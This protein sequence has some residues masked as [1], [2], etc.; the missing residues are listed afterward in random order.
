[1]LHRSARAAIQPARCRGQ[2]AARCRSRFGTSRQCMSTE[3][4]A[5]P[6][7]R[8]CARAVVVLAEDQVAARCRTRADRSAVTRVETRGVARARPERG[9]YPVV[10]G[11]ETDRYVRR[12]REAGSNTRPR[13]GF[14]VLPKDARSMRF[15]NQL[16]QWRK[17]SAPHSTKGRSNDAKTCRSL[18]N[19]VDHSACLPYRRRHSTPAH[20]PT[21]SRRSCHD[22]ETRAPRDART[23]A[24]ERD[25]D[26]IR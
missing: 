8:E 9:P 20:G 16:C 21:S 13:V 3:C 17:V 11:L 7:G 15:P 18:S 2:C 6:R 24:C 25:D 4:H 14:P 19:A 26:A 5:E 1:M 23:R 22:H 12:I 10:R